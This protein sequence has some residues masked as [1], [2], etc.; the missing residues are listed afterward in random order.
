MGPQRE[1]ASSCCIVLVWFRRGVGAVWHD[2]NMKLALLWCGYGMVLVW[3]CMIL[4]WFWYGYGFGMLRYGLPTLVAWLRCDFGVVL[5]WLW[6]GVGVRLA[7]FLYDCGMVIT[8][9]WY[10][11]VMVLKLVW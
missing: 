4:V 1:T 7:L 11:S 9:I 5:A 3:F 2:F 6:Y 8:W 10:G